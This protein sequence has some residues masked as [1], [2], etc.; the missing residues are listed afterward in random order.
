[1]SPV[2]VGNRIEAVAAGCMAGLAWLGTVQATEDRDK[3]MKAIYERPFATAAQPA[4]LVLPPGAVE[5]TG[6]LRD[7]CLTMRDGFTACMDEVD[8]A[9]QQ[10]W[11]K[12]FQMRGERLDWQKGAWPYEGGGYW[13]DGLARLGFVL[14][15]EVL[16]QQAKKR[17]SAVVD[18]MNDRSILFLWWLDRTKQE[19]LDA[20]EGRPKL[21][22]IWSL[23]GSGLFGRALVGYYAGSQD[24]A[25]LNA[26]EMAYGD[27]Y[28][29]LRLIPRANLWAAFET[30][31]WSGSPKMK[32]ALN[33]LFADPGKIA[34]HGLGSCATFVKMPPE[35]FWPKGSY[36][37]I[38]LPESTAVLALGYLWTGR[39]EFLDTAM[40]WHDVMRSHAMQPHG[41]ATGDEY[42]CP[43]GAARASETCG[44]TALMW[45]Q[46]E[47]MRIGGEGPLA[48][49]TERAFFNAAANVV[50]RDCQTHVYMQEPNRVALDAKRHYGHLVYQRKHNPLCCTATLNRMLPNYVAN[51]W[52][53]TDDNG[54]AAVHYGPC[55]VSARVADGV[56]CR[57]TCTTDYPFSENIEIAVAPE[58][59]T[60]F[61]LSFRIPGWCKAAALKINGKSVGLSADA[62]GFAHVVRSWKPGDKVRLDFPM[63]PVVETGIDRNPYDKIKLSYDGLKS[64]QMTTG[65]APYATVSYG[66]LLF[67]LPIPDTKDANT[68]D[69]ATPWRFA[70]DVK[71]QGKES[72]IEVERG[73]M[74]AKWDWPLDAPLK[75]SVPV[76]ACDWMPT[77]VQPL[78]LQPVGS[79]VAQKITLIPYGC[80]KF[81]VTMFPV[82]RA[83]WDGAGAK[84][85]AGR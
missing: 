21:D 4:F 34:D 43:P 18:N 84:A 75:L 80:A 13:F 19:D 40:R 82:T 45:S 55:R 56:K 66:P 52:M 73:P 12:D 16:I 64:A 61:P 50:S 27:S 68:P 26:L 30:Y 41:A 72:D 65:T 23:W 7:W 9:F 17:F 15:D 76:V 38:T 62:K 37:N 69:P 22:T 79:V 67:A 31:T 11:A 1:M 5:P 59:E 51:M 28:Q 78:P 29:W 25:A 83:G 53:A 63:Q 39:R 6:W 58:R 57:L 33:E 85:H 48:D 54:L 70:L 10:A 44:I 20:A 81:R 35:A 3:P 24:R 71:G 74:P 14:H 2:S 47:L 77:P 49:R 36:H 42:Y 46:I 8:P 32:A 60:T